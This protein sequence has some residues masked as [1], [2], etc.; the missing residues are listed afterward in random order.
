MRSSTSG[1]HTEFAT[2]PAATDAQ[3]RAKPRPTGGSDGPGCGP[4]P[5]TE[6]GRST[7]RRPGRVPVGVRI[8]TSWVCPQPVTGRRRESGPK[9]PR[10]GT[11]RHW[12]SRT[13]PRSDLADW[14]TP[15]PS[16]RQTR[17]DRGGSVGRHRLAAPAAVI[18]AAAAALS[19]CGLPSAL[20]G[21]PDPPGWERVSAR[22]LVLKGPVEAYQPDRLIASG[23]F[24]GR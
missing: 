17:A 5:V 14:A 23:S 19:S 6:D 24:Q 2:R 16:A 11:H 18:A 8:M 22:G 20:G 3:S 1:P 7:R 4:G 10:T 12:Q 21:E 13:D 15:W 9:V